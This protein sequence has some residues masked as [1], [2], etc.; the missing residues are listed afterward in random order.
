MNRNLAPWLTKR[1]P[2]PATVA[3]VERMVRSADLHTVCESARCPN[4]GECWSR[5]TATFMIL[6]NI[7]T[8]NCGFC[9]IGVGR[10]LPPDPDE[11]RRVAEAASAMGLRH[12][13]VTSVTRDDLPDKG[14]GHFAATIA[15]I[16]DALPDA[17]V[18]VLTPDFQGSDDL[19]G[20]VVQESPDIFNHNLETVARLTAAVRPQGRYERSL[21]VLATAKRLA[22]SMVT[23]S[24][25]M[26]GLGETRE[27]VLEAMRDLRDAEVSILTVG[28][29]LRPTMRHLAVVEYVH[30][31]VFDYYG[32]AA[33][34]MGFTHVSSSPFTRSS[35]KAEEFS[36][37]RAGAGGSAA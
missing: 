13:V 24:G 37:R 12:V 2:S 8:R 3:E 32:E 9:A 16:R 28:Q 6:G 31:D 4:Q 18:E 26:V 33:L 22:P 35:Y 7:C 14:A 36:P 20:V 25:I 29:Y 34:S 1:I 5:R 17:G 11:P 23:K 27:E 15:A 10:P 19:I 21:H 30:P